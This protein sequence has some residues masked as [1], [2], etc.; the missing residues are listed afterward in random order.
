[1]FHFIQYLS[2]L[3]LAKNEFLV[4][5]TSSLIHLIRVTHSNWSQ[6]LFGSENQNESG[7][8]IALPPKVSLPRGLAFL[9]SVSQFNQQTKRTAFVPYLLRNSTGL[10]LKFAQM[11]SLPNVVVTVGS[12]PL[13]GN[14]TFLNP[15]REL[16]SPTGQSLI[17]TSLEETSEWRSVSPG[18]EVP[19]NF[20]TK[21]NAIRKRVIYYC[22][23]LEGCGTGRVWCWKGVVLEGCGTGR[24]WYWKGVVLEGCGVG[25]VW[26]W[27]G[28]VLEGCGTG[29]VWYWK[30]AVL[31]GCGVGRVRCWKGVVLL[32]NGLV[33][34]C[35]VQVTLWFIR[36]LFKWMDGRELLFQFL[37]IKLV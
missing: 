22:I 24:V 37:L 21:R 27:K 8:G 28:V 23:A 29:R 32:V 30:G 18:E 26:Y 16:S 14:S 5:V 12:S 34:L 20:E 7:S 4:N 9:H 31:E 17:V 36:Y 19:F 10:P 3:C 35:R 6:D 2:V 25:R 15:S 33:V 11:A 13:S 1:M